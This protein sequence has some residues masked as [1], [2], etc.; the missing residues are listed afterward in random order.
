MGRSREFAIRAALGASHMRV[1]RQLL[2]ESIL[3]A[4]LGGALG[5]LLAFWGTR[6]VLGTLP[7]ALPRANEISLDSRVLLFTM[8]LS[9]FAG[10]VFGLAPALKTSRVN[11]QEIL[12]ESGRGLSGARHRL[13]GV[14]VAVE[15]AHGPGAARRRG[16]DGAQP[17]GA[18]ARESRL[19][20]QPR[21]YF[22][23]V[24][25]GR[26]HHGVRRNARAVAPIRRQ[27]A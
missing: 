8:A 19:Q 6:A 10:I 17:C 20:S 9:L 15:V 23:L 22:Q 21:D 13:Q 1:M 14:F 4:G 26:I 7:G 27:D 2:T 18:L 25:A 16:T 12:K 24:A 5:L 3:L 11:L